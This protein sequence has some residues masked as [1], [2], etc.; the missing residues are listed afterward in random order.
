ME[1]QNQYLNNGKP[2]HTKEITT[3]ISW[4][5]MFKIEIGNKKIENQY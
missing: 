4:K 1:N 3:V 2:V 5:P